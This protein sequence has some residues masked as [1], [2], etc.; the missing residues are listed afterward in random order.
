[1][2]KIRIFEKSKELDATDWIEDFEFIAKIQGWS[3]EDWIG[4][5][6]LFLGK[7][8]I[9]WYKKSRK[10]FTDWD[11]F[12]KLF[13]KQHSEEYTNT[14]IWTKLRTISSVNFDSWEEFED[15]IETLMS[16]VGIKEDEARF[17][18]IVSAL[19]AELQVQV[20]EKGL[21][22]KAELVTLIQ[23]QT[24]QT[25]NKESPSTRNTQVKPKS[26]TQ[27]AV[28]KGGRSVKEMTEA[29]QY[30]DFLKAFQEM[31]VSIINKI[32]E[33]VESKANRP[34]QNHNFRQEVECYYCHKKGHISL[35]CPSR[36]QPKV[37]KVVEMTEENNINFIEVLP[38]EQDVYAYEKR[39]QRDEEG[40]ETRPTKTR[41]TR[42]GDMA[43]ESP[44]IDD[45]IGLGKKWKES[46]QTSI[47]CNWW[48]RRPR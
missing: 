6:K 1:M 28:T 10:D 39:K 8:E 40:R 38:G 25:T 47:C 15:E 43:R 13:V 27:S 11:T 48:K 34:R 26:S 24:I 44:T 33:L 31:S 20:E 29:G 42:Q 41:N 19:P 46:T 21:K 36:Q 37:E 4:I 17:G 2:D 14:N 16:K 23:K 32:D 5:V 45:D 9:L 7:K 30:G 18:L 3:K 35:R 12:K 22:T